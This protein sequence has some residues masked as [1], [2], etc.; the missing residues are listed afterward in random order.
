MKILNKTKKKLGLCDCKGC[1]RL[2]VI[3][4]TIPVINHKGQLC[5]KHFNRL[6]EMNVFNIKENNNDK[7][8]S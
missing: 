1:F 7:Q 3:D 5:N 2:A 8:Q 4:Y 6:L